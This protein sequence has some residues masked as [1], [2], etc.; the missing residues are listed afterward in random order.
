MSQ[1][2]DLG[3]LLHLTA[4]GEGGRHTPHTEIPIIV[5]SCLS[6]A[7]LDNSPWVKSPSIQVEKT[8]SHLKP[9]RHEDVF[10]WSVR[11]LPWKRKTIK[12]Q[13]VDSK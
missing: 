5:T 1:T 11:A 9:N 4:K 13:F 7:F 6:Y 12:A 10:K 2:G 3:C 8:T